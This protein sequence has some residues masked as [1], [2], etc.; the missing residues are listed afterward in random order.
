MTK[1]LLSCV[2]I[3]PTTKPVASIIWLHGLGADGHDFAGIVPELNLAKE[4]AI[5]F[6]F[7]HAPVKPITINAGFPMR[8]WYDIL[9][10]DRHSHED[11]TGIRES[12]K[13]VD[14]LIENEKSKGMPAHKIIIAGFSQG[15][16]MALH[17]GLRH[18]ERLGG[19]LALSC[20]LPLNKTL[21]KEA[22]PENN[23]IPIFMAHGKQDNIVPLNFG[24]YS[25][26]VLREHGYK[27]EFKTYPMAH[28][29]CVEEIVDI[30]NW[31]KKIIS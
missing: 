31:F 14:A 5:R 9:G 3:N 11:G 28:E 4:L 29:V 22:A 26:K 25:E 1:E 23:D 17:T 27:V 12:Q 30:S 24:E 6:V 7:P 19:I 20:Y 10:L 18:H 8:A 16:A 13:L 21:L 2:E 15:G